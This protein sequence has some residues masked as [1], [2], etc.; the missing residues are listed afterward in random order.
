MINKL[1]F[2]G[3]KITN[4]Q[5]IPDT[6]YRH[7]C[8]FSVRLQSELRNYGNRFLEYVPP[9]IIDSVCLAPIQ[10]KVYRILS[11]LTCKDDV[12]LAIKKIKPMKA[13][14]HDSI[15]TQV[16]QPCPEIF[17][18]NL[19]KI[20]NNAIS[21][22]VYPN[23]MKIA[24]II[25]LFK[26]GVKANPSYYIPISLLSHFDKIYEKMYAKDS[27]HSWSKNKYCIVISMDFENCILQEWFW[28]RLQ[29]ISS[30]FLT[31]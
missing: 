24:K 15:G 4:K 8:D 26:G 14:G 17:A 28:L 16:I 27:L 20:F 22:G 19:S 12:L 2:A 11:Y 23:A 29:T 6:M 3:K 30:A 7:F 9:R 31:K 10:N 13:P 18:E 1:V 5:V 25:A 21:R